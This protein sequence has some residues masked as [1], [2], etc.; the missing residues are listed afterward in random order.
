MPLER[1]LAQWRVPGSAA[2]SADRIVRILLRGIAARVMTVSPLPLFGGQA[3]YATSANA[4]IAKSIRWPPTKSP[5]K[6]L[7]TTA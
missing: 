4:T 3:A 5:P 6:A 2:H 1:G 7:A